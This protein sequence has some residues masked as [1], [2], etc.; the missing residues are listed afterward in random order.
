MQPK[1][2][3]IVIKDQRTPE[4]I[5]GHRTGPYGEEFLVKFAGLSIDF[6]LWL[7]KDEC[8][9]YE[10]IERYLRDINEASK[11]RKVEKRKFHFRNESFKIKDIMKGLPMPKDASSNQKERCREVPRTNPKKKNTFIDLTRM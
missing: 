2:A 5:I 4:Q 8:G 1:P 7:T 9:D 3:P 10:M 6:A 11:V